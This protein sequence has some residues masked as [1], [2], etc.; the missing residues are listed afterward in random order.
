MFHLKVFL[1]M[2]KVNINMKHYCC[3]LQGI[4]VKFWKEGK[5]LLIRWSFAHVITFITCSEWLLQCRAGSFSAAEFQ[6]SNRRWEVNWKILKEYNFCIIT[7]NAF[8]SIF[9]MVLFFSCLLLQN[10]VLE[11]I[12]FWRYPAFFKAFHFVK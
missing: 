11:G 5:W 12:S 2:W 10:A 4:L 6:D 1:V 8:L 9:C 7:S 3:Y